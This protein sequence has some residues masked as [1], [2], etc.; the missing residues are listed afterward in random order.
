MLYNALSTMCFPQDY[1]FN[2]PT[3]KFNTAFYHPNVYSD[4]R[5]CI[6]ILHSPGDDPLSGE[7]AE[8]RW[9][10][11]QTVESILLSVVSLLNDPNCSSPA[12]VDAGIMYRQDREQY[13]KIILAQALASRKD[14]PAE[15]VL[16]TS[17]ESYLYKAPQVT[18]TDDEDFW[19][20]ED[21]DF[22]D[23]ED[24]DEDDI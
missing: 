18:P 6:S 10:P 13:D 15:Y 21:Q 19:Y 1:P 16:P 12:N 11:T 7:K 5:I 3:F 8:E 22:D 24:E 17:V 9:N 2:P 4:G 14:I 20:D 23:D